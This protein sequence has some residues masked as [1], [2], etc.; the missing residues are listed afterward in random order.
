[1]KRPCVH[2]IC[3]AHLDP[4]WQ[5]QWEEGFSEAVSTFR[6]AARLLRE[7]PT[8]IFNH[9]EAVLYRWVKKLDLPLFAEIQR[10]VAEERWM[11]GGGW[12]LQPDANL[13]GTES[14][15]RHITEGRRFFL[16]HFGVRPRVAYNF[17][18]FGHSGGLPQI[19]KKAGYDMYIHMRPQAGELELPSDLYRWRGVDGTEILAYRI[20]VGLYH[21]EYDNIEQRLHEGVDLALRLNRDVP[22]FWGIGDHGGG[23]TREDLAKIDAFIQREDR[24]EIIHSTPERFCDA[25]WDDAKKAPLFEGGLQRVFTGCYTSLSRLKRAAQH[26]LGALTRA[27]TLQALAW[28]TMGRNYAEKELNE[29]WRLHLFNDFHDIIAGTCIEPSERDALIHYGT[30]ED[31]IRRLNLETAAYINSRMKRCPSAAEEA[32]REKT[33]KDSGEETTAAAAAKERKKSGIKDE[34]LNTKDEK[35]EGNKDILEATEEAK[36]GD[37]ETGEIPLTILHGLPSP[38]KYP[39]EA[40][41]MISH[42]PKWTGTWKLRLVDREGKD[43]PYQEEQP[44]ALLPFNGWRRKIVFLDESDGCGAAHYRVYPVE[45]DPDRKERPPAVRFEFGPDNLIEKWSI[46]GDRQVLA[47][48][49]LQ[50]L[51]VEDEGDSWGTG[52]WSYRHIAGRFSPDKPG[53]KI[54]ES[55]PVRTVYEAHFTYNHSRIVMQTLVYTDWPVLEFRLRIHW[56][57]PRRRLKLSLP[58]VLKSGSLISEIPGGII[59]RPADGQEH[60]HG[61]WCVVEGS[62]GGKKAAIGIAHTGC[63]GLDF[64]DGELRLSVLRSAVYCHEKG[65]T[66]GSF[67]TPKFMDLGEH[68]IRLLAIGGAPEDVRRHLP[69]LADR[70]SAPLIVYSHLP[71]GGFTTHETTSSARELGLDFENVL[72]LS[73]ANVRLLACKRSADGKALILRIQETNG[74]PAQ[75]DIRI[76]HPGIKASVPLKPM[77][78]KTLRIERNGDW[79]EVDLVDET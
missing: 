7:H 45:G 68:D 38:G 37:H 65:L 11:I 51:V 72:T 34:E 21:T 18:S 75:A 46:D 12:Y 25:V 39:I 24:V 28:W 20:A 14:L 4:V 40:E 67:P 54:I 52:L 27:E 70:L 13:P 47:G 9:N 64:K 76:S 56:N 61:R 60:V 49:L 62:L 8:L 58:T 35:D 63:H 53:L 10:L 78:I 66:L 16:Y 73:P 17:D 77:E 15:I 6:C 50:P 42:R 32:I 2:L 26:S 79:R 5:W 43:V 55:G 22:V 48:P 36:R 23:A 69:G 59:G 31:I 33:N 57:E 19:L 41:L 1:M 71:H 3:T 74:A 29:A 30:A 44:E